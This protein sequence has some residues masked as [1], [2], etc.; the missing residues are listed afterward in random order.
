MFPLLALMV[1]GVEG[2]RAMGAVLKVMGKPG[3]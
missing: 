3:L 2:E 1:R